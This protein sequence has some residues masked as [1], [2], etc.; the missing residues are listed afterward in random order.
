LVNILYLT[1]IF[2]F[3]QYFC[4]FYPIS[5]SHTPYLVMQLLTQCWFIHLISVQC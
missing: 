2:L 4:F 1:H 5:H 3:R